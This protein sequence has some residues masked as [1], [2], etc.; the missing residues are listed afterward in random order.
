M[1]QWSHNAV[2]RYGLNLRKT[3]YCTFWSIYLQERISTTGFPE[4]NFFSFL[5]L[6]GNWGEGGG[7]GGRGIRSSVLET[8]Q[9]GVEV[10][11]A[12]VGTRFAEIDSF[13]FHDFEKSLR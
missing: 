2:T 7:V 8:V 1:G 10:V 11:N 4:L 12:G 6:V 9:N 13:C 5:F 3:F